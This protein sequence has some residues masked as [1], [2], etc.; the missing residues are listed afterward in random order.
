MSGKVLPIPR[1]GPSSP[2]ADYYALRREGIGYIE[3]M[4][5]ALW[6]DYNTHDPGITILEGLCYAITELAY[7][8]GWD[9]KDLLAP[10]GGGTAPA[11]A[12]FSAR[13]ILTVNPVTPDDWRRLLLGLPEVR[14]AWVSCKECACDVVHYAWCEPGGQPR[15]GWRRPADPGLVPERVDVR[16][17]LDVLVELEADPEA[18]DLNDRKVERSAAVGA[19]GA[20]QLV[21]ELRFPDWSLARPQEWRAFIGDDSVARA[22]LAALG[23]RKDYDVLTDPLLDEAGRDR[24][25][26]AHWKG[27]LY[28][29]L[30][31]TIDPGGLVVPLGPAALHLFGDNAAR[32]ALTGAWLKAQLEDTGADGFVARYR[33]KARKAAA[34]VAAARALLQAHR[35]LDEDFCRVE[36]VGIEDVAVCADIE[37]AAGAD[38]ERVQAEAWLAIERYFNPPLPRYRLQELL[39]QGLPVEDIF[40]GPQSAGGFVTPGDLAASGLRQVLRGSD[41]INLLM[42]IEGVRAISSLLLT[43]YDA[44]GNPVGAPSAACC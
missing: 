12:F 35:N 11:Q 13:E 44:D 23:S 24:Y 16:G 27:A 2:A 8:C 6:S 10:P 7:R 19:G 28:A 30:V 37:V 29:S 4:G 34:A 1:Q 32:D 25:L 43:K 17:M 21:L 40:D 14:N 42:D 41:L 33:A 18:G 5:S 3:Q 20:A 39:E 22:E 36:P 31:L 38:I 26:R 9:I 15:L